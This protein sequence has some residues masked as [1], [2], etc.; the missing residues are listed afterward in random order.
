MSIMSKLS[1]AWRRFIERHL[2]RGEVPKAL[3]EWQE[4]FCQWNAERLGIVPQESLERFRVSCAALKG[5]HA[6]HHFKVYCEINHDLCRVFVGN[7]PQEIY[8][9]YHLHAPLH[10]LRM[11]SYRVP[12]WPEHLPEVAVIAEKSA[13]VIVDFGCGLAQLSIS[14]A[15]FLKKAG[16]SPELFLADIPVPQLEFLRWLCAQRN[17]KATFAECTF[18][19]PIPP[20]P[21]CDLL[22]ATELFEHLHDPVPYLKAFASVIKP[23]GFLLTNI[24]DHSPE[25]LHISPGLAPLREFL[26]SAGW[27]ELRSNRIFQ[28]P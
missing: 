15:Q 1:V 20:L 13:P 10:F 17:L 7:R 2:V 21:A 22:V 11:L 27:R 23:G 25:F 6:G 12:V 4:A 26:R 24:G 5:G 8:Q 16:R 9:A 3:N 14:L 18:A 28:K 19:A